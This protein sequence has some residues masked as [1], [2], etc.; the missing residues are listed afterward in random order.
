M[1]SRSNRGTSFEKQDRVHFG[2]TATGIAILIAG[3]VAPLTAPTAWAQQA[4]SKVVILGEDLSG[5]ATPTGQ[6]QVVGSL[7]LDPADSRRLAATEGRGNILN[8]PTGRTSNLY[9]TFEHGDVIAHVEFMVPAGSNSGVYFQG[10]YEIQILDSWGVEHPKYGD[11]G[12]IYQRWKDGQGYEGHAP[13]VNASRPPGQWQSF[14]VVFRAPRFDAEGHKVANACFVKVLHNGVVVHENVEVTGPT[15]GSAFDDEK[16]TGPLMLQGDHGPVAYRNI[17]LQPISPQKDET[18]DDLPPSHSVQ[19]ELYAKG[20]VFA[21]GPALDDAGNLYVVNYQRNGTIGRIA[22][23]RSGSI[24]CDVQALSP[25]GD[26]Q[27]RI[28]GLKIDSQGRLIAADAGAGRVLRISPDGNRVEVLAESFAGE[29]FRVI[30]DVALDLAGNIF[31]TDP[32]GSSDKNPIGSVY[33]YDIHS[34]EVTRLDTGLAYPN[35]LGVTPDQRHLCVAESAAYRLWIYDLQPDGS[36]ANRRVLIEFPKETVGNIVG[37]LHHPD[38]MVFDAQGRLYQAMWTGG[39]INVV[40]VNTGKLIRQYNAGGSKATNCHFHGDYLYV[41][42]AADEA[43][44]RLHLGVKGF[45]YNGPGR[46]TP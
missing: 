42:V 22:P 25:A 6:W 40:D 38:G 44:Y 31:F 36:V 32:G 4:D 15:R 3:I 13:R 26:R 30:N 12:G 35:G 8:G 24:F 7:K 29:R 28:N 34:G 45:D 46:T 1:S 39:V 9:S 2:T 21:E 5:F 33:R 14:D 41:T 19:P 16:P 43:V 20:F 18:H 23:D 37:G 11:C 17:W 27:P 10:R